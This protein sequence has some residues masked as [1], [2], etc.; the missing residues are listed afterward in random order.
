MFKI[1]S[2]LLVFF[3]MFTTSCFSQDD[4]SVKLYDS[5]TKEPISFATVRFVGTSRGI[6]ADYYGY[7]RLPTKIKDSILKLK[8]TALGYESLL[9]E[10]KNLRTQGLN[11]FQMKPRVESLDAVVLDMSKRNKLNSA[12]LTEL[13]NAAR[14]LLAFEI[15]DKAISKIPNNL[16][17]KPHS[18]VGYY[19]DYQFLDNEYYNLNEGVIE[20]YDDGIDSNLLT[21]YENKK[22]LYYFKANTDFKNDSLLTQSYDN[23]FKYIQNAKVLG[24]GGNEYILLKVHN[25]IRNYDMITF[26]YVY[27]LNRHFIANHDFTKGKIEFLED[28]PIINI[29]FNTR[30]VRDKDVGYGARGRV[31]Q[32]PYHLLTESSSDNY[33]TRISPELP[34]NGKIAISLLD[35]SIYEFNYSLYDKS[36]K[37]IMFSTALEYRKLGDKMYLNYISFSNGFTINVDD[38]FKENRAS[39]N[40]DDHSFTISFNRNLNPKSLKT[41]RFKIKYKNRRIAISDLE[42]VNPREVKLVVSEREIE[43]R[44][45]EE[46]QSQDFS[47][48]IKKILDENKNEIYKPISKRAYQFREFFVQEVFQNKRP[49]PQLMYMNR[50]KPLLQAPINDS[51]DADTYIINSPLKIKHN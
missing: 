23:Q 32:T 31:N 49:D 19:R 34:A 28:E 18:Y 25:P 51:L 14:D 13:I 20:Q 39:Y 40:Q 27:Q 46:L 21:D 44:Q 38:V 1:S 9:I 7:F 50:L 16:S 2:I 45:Q 17:T 35:F 29:L 22:A 33:Y 41:R 37:D 10:T 12:Q 43:L 47:L 24:Y 30:P 48:V 42:L 11:N 36:K 4:I 5:E 26:S 15:V 8:I 3:V 6:V